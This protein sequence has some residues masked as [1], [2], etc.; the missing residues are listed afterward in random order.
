MLFGIFSRISS[1]TMSGIED[2]A[3]DEDKDEVEEEEEDEEA[4]AAAARRKREAPNAHAMKKKEDA[5]C[6]VQRSMRN[7]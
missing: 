6:S 3:G 4:A 7:R 2:G 5:R 1:G